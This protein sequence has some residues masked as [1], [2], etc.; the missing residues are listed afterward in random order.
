[1]KGV[2]L[3]E[4]KE[5]KSVILTNFSTVRLKREEDDICVV[6]SNDTKSVMN[7]RKWSSSLLQKGEHGRFE[8]PF[9]ILAFLKKKQTLS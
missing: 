3:E 7:S 9:M 2:I 6:Q 1:M 5:E 4:A 8:T